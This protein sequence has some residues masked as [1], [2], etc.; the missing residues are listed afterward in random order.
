MT[1]VSNCTSYGISHAQYYYQ[2]LAKNVKVVQYEKVFIG[3]EFQI[4]PK[5]GID[6]LVPVR[7]NAELAR[8]VTNRTRL[9][10]NRLRTIRLSNTTPTFWFSH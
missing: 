9:S 10:T 4:P 5:L 1:G 8:L 7:G 6:Y 2:G 3:T